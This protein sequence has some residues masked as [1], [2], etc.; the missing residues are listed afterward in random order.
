MEVNG[1]KQYSANKDDSMVNEDSPVVWDEHLFFELKN[2]APE[3][4]KTT[5]VVIR[6][7]NRGWVRNELVGQAMLDLS[8]VYF[9]ENHKVEHVWMGLENPDSEDF[10]N[11]KGLLKIS[12]N[13][14]GPSD[15]AQK[16]EP[17]FGPEPAVLNMFISPSIKRT[18]Y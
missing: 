8:S 4:A 14:T 12:A 2:L 9:K 6:V 17:Q 1:D 15:N 5:M 18:F 13:V 3:K 10:E 11:M 16:L 7:M